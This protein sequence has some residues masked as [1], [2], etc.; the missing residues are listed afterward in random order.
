[1]MAV[2]LDLL[3]L[4]TGVLT[5]LGLYISFCKVGPNFD[6]KFRSEAVQRG[7]PARLRCEAQ[8]DPPVTLTW[9]KDG[10]SLGPPATD[11]R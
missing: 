9:A 3:A 11:Q 8:G 5:C 6:T 1:M 10:Q 4:L 7:G 2:T